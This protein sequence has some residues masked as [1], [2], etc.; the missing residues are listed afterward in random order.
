[1]GP[2]GGVLAAVRIAL[3]LLERLRSREPGQPR[4][5]ANVAIAPNTIFH[6]YYGRLYG[7]PALE[8]TRRD[9]VVI[10][11][12]APTD[13]LP[14]YDLKPQT[15]SYYEAGIAHT[16]PHGMYGYVNVWERNVWNV[17]DTTQIYPTPIFAV[18]NNSLGP[19]PRRGIAA[20]GQQPDGVV[21]SVG[22]VFAVGR[23]RRS[24]A[25]RSCS[26]P[27]RSPTTRCSPKITIKRWHQRCLHANA[28]ATGSRSTPRRD[29]SYGTGYPVQFQN[30]T[31]RLTPHLDIQR[32]GRAR[33]RARDPRLQ[34]DVQ[35]IADYQYLIKVNN[36]F[37]TTQWA[38][39]S[40]VLFQVKALL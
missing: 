10:G 9:A 23:G 5:G 26:R 8:D 36:G 38:P 30:G 16:F 1:M 15:E 2:V 31:G 3:R 24:P 7:A 4:I 27:T 25:E 40:Q 22:S 18:Y 33:A 13:V 32:L 11:G 21:V 14:V 29:S 12:G 20:P 37:N 6:A 17:L 39:G 35:N 28:S 34:L 19:R